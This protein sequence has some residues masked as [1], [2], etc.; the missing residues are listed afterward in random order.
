MIGLDTNILARYFTRDDETQWQQVVDLLNS[1]ET[2]FIPYIVLCELVWLLQGKRY[3]Y[4]KLEILQLVETMLHTPEFEFE[5]RSVIYQAI[6][7]TR[8]GRA[9]FS[10]YLIGILAQNQGCRET[11]TFDQKLR[12][13]PGFC[14]LGE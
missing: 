8:Q 13:Q 5:S 12:E 2:F 1:G 3:A 6:Q 9:D 11:V 10:D 14:I 7:L 4:A